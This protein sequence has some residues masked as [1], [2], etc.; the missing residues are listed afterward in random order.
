MVW[1]SRLPPWKSWKGLPPLLNRNSGK[2]ATM[3]KLPASLFYWGDFIREPGLRRCS[4]AA[5]GVWIKCLCLMFDCEQ[6]GV[7]ATG[8]VPWSD[9]DIALAVGGQWD[10]TNACLTELVT[11]GVASRN[12]EG[13]LMCRRMYREEKTRDDTR[14]RVQ[15]FR[16]K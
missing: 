2:P 8:G 13:S 11:K 7:L 10:E 4:N 1:G 9:A 12:A 14:R 3:G 6:K 16:E 15:K 5:V